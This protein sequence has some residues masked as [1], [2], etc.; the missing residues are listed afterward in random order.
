[1]YMCIILRKSFI[2]VLLL[3]NVFTLIFDINTSVK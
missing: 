1:M 3:V 2:I